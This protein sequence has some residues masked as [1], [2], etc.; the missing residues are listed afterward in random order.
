MGE[1]RGLTEAILARAWQEGMFADEMRT[2]EGGRLRVVYRG[3]WTFSNGPDFRD[4]MLE[5][6][7]RLVRGSVEL[8][9][10]SSDWWRHG[11]ESDPAYD[12]VVLHV[13]LEYDAVGA[14]GP[15]GVA[16]P[17]VR[18]GD[19]LTAPI[20]QMRV[21]IRS[22]VLG[23][24]GSRPCLPTLAGGREQV[25][26]ELLAR[27][28]WRRM[29]AK[30]LAF[31]QALED[32]TAGEVLKR[33]MLDALGLSQNRAGMAAVADR[34]PLPMLERA[35]AAGG[36]A[37]RG[38]LLG[39]GGFLPLTPQHA[40]TADLSADEV[41][42]VESAG[43]RLMAEWHL[44]S[45]DDAVWELNRVRP[46]NHPVR[47]LASFAD[48]MRSSAGDGLLATV[49]SVPLE[50]PDAWRRWLRLASPRLGQ[51]RADQIAV[52]VIAPFLAAYADVMGEQG[53]SERI[54]EVWETMPGRPDDVIARQ[55]LQQICGDMPF[56]VKRAIEV[57][58]LHQI[59]RNGCRELRCFECPIAHLAAQF[60]APIGD[61]SLIRE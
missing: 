52:N 42:T 47:R 27:E 35:A 23:P 33:G 59:G 7:D 49:L 6:D 56:V 3:V 20:E 53:L 38:V 41:Q 28:G 13:V 30:R 36:D 54:G 46:T 26:H 37:V 4:A 44:A 9:L 14:C 57:Q 12:D 32:E 60:E 18:L 31:R 34:L 39:V 19:F 16:I 1:E 2:V 40:A 48:C 45:V 5:I 11:H 51:S 24:T 25:V 15:R 29:T 21:D 50:R 43:M 58:G 8:H 61:I 22:V 17:T 10:R 55:T